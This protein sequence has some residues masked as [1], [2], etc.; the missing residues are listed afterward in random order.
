V[1]ILWPNA[2]NWP[3]GGEIDF[4]ETDSA[5]T[6]VAFF[7]HYNPSNEQVFGHKDLDITQF[8]NYAVEWVDGRITGYIDG[9]KFFESTDDDTMPPGGMHPT[10]QLDYFPDGGDPKPSEMIVDFMRIYE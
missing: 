2:E 8:H 4:A 3:A 10:I 1:L 9:E 6:S 5:A 7:L